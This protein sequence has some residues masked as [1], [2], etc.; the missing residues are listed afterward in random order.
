MESA[1]DS[2]KLYF[3]YQDLQK[4]MKSLAVRL[5]DDG[6]HFD[7]IVTI[8]SGGFI[9]AR[10]LKT[11]M[12]IPIYAVNVSYYDS[13]DIKQ[14]EPY[15]IQW[16]SNPKEEIQGK[17]VLLVD[18]IDDSR[19]TLAFCTAKLLEN[20]PR[21][22]TVAVMHN[23]KAVKSAQLPAGVPYYAGEEIEDK[24]AC[25]PWE[26]DDIDEHDRLTKLFRNSR[27]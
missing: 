7:C 1:A 19:S 3:S 22:L 16:L 6:Y 17:S 23:K 20:R 14:S 25:Y 27:K 24:W 10:M 5:A 12:K 2:E 18:E 11:Y 8:A 26:A 15:I 4:T 9:P 13:N 21:Q